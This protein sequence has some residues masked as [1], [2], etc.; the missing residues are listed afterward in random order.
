MVRYVITINSVTN[1]LPA[2]NKYDFQC[3]QHHTL[4]GVYHYAIT[5][6]GVYD[7]DHWWG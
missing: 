5:I 3:Y 2:K 6:P 7:L 4:G 1:A